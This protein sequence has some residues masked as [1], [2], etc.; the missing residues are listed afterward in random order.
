MWFAVLVELA[1]TS[2]Q[3][4]PIVQERSL[5]PLFKRRQEGRHA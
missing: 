3:V 5:T 1:P 4:S 2:A